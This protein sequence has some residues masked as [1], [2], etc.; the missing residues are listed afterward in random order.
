MKLCA[1]KYRGITFFRCDDPGWKGA[2]HG[3]STRL[4]GCSTSVLDSLNLGSNQGDAPEN[5]RENFRRFQQAIGAEPG[6]P[7][8]K[9][10]QV[11]TAR[12]RVVTEKDAVPD[13]ALGGD[14]DADAMVTD[15]PGLCLTAFSAD[16]LPI[17]FYDPQRKVV[18][19]AHAGWR[20]TAQGVAGAVVQMME[21]Q[22]HCEAADILCAIGPGISSCCFETHEDVPQALIQCLGQSAQSLIH[23]QENGKFLV[24]L[25]GANREILLRSGLRAEHLAISDVC[26]AC[27]PEWFW[28]HRVLGS[29]RGSMAAMIQLAT[30]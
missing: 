30:E 23:P 21:K 7:L 17:L 29:Q 28:S 15:C 2:N 1:V 13:L 11:H 27:R 5:V 25:K 4:G 9:N 24:D 3:F 26:T 19:A 16:C 12:V 6:A 14:V 18:A 8:V 10:H 20:G 22:Y